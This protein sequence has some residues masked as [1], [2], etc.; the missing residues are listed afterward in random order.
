MVFLDETSCRV[1]AKY[2]KGGVWMPGRVAVC[3]K[4]DTEVRF[5]S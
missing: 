3:R 2:R 1:T 4:D 5:R